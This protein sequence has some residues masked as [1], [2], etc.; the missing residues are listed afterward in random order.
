[1]SS[2]LPAH[3]GLLLVNQM[4]H[5]K[6]IFVY[7][8]RFVIA[9]TKKAATTNEVAQQIESGMKTITAK[10]INQTVHEKTRSSFAHGTKRS[11][12]I[13]QWTA[14]NSP[15]NS[16]LTYTREARKTVAINVQNLYT[17]NS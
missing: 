5:V 14:T 6:R 7:Y 3:P 2:S 17:A 9:Y 11:I 15:M 13:H 1:M 16:E 8:R 12:Q 10:S 4:R